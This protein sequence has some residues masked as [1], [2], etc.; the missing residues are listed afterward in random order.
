SLFIVDLGVLNITSQKPAN[1]LDFFDKILPDGIFDYDIY[2]KL[3]NY[4]LN[5]K[6]LSFGGDTKALAV[7]AKLAKHE[8]PVD[9]KNIKTFAK[10]VRLKADENGTASYEFKT[11]NGFNSA[12]R[13]DAVSSNDTQMDAKHSQII[14][15][16]D[17]II[18][19]TVLA[20]M[21][22]GDVLNA[23]LRLINTTNQDKNL[24]ILIKSSPNLEL[25]TDSNVS[26][27]PLENKILPLKIT[28]KDIGKAN[29]NIE[30]NDGNNIMNNETNLDIISPYPISTYARSLTLS[31][32]K[33]IKLPQGFRN[34]S[35][36]ASNSVTSLLSA[37]SENL[38]QYPYGCAE[39]RSSRLLALLNARVKENFKQEDRKRFIT[40]GLQELIKKQKRDGSFGYWDELSYV[41]TFASIYATDL[42]LE[43]DAA[44]YKVHKSVK[45]QALKS[46]EGLKYETSFELLY[47]LYLSAKNNIIDRSALNSIY[48]QKI[49]TSSVLNKYLMASALKI[50]GLDD[51]AQ[52][53]LKNLNATDD[54]E[55]RIYSD[56]H[57][58][59]RDRA[60]VLY[61]HAKHFKPNS[62]SDELANF[63][64]TNMDNLHSTQERAFALR[65]L[66]AYFKPTADETN[67]KFKLIY[68]GQDREFDGLLSVNITTKNGEFR[69]EPQGENKLFAGISSS[70]Y[71]PLEIK[72]AI[73][74]K[75]LDIYRIF[76][77]KNGK[78]VNL[79]SLKV[80]DVIYSK[81]TLNS[82]SPIANGVI[83]EIVSPCFEV[84][85]ENLSGFTRDESAKNNITLEYQTIKDDRV[86]SFY[87]L[88]NKKAALFTPYRVVMSGK[89]MLPAVITENMYNDTQNDYDLAQKSFTIK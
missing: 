47:A 34:V 5:G 31:N 65:A 37:A 16:D 11:P 35:I 4:R 74:P 44:G 53:A 89:C 72:H 73:E 7:E 18:K 32:P 78:E 69:L 52:S 30:L 57:S 1:P 55:K 50:L 83:N 85:N 45:E 8:S 58:D 84:V 24:R 87:N 2:D 13:V 66:N 17:V 81:I 15:K 54:K 82:K 42:V 76:V 39:Q 46:L 10:S 41:N 12:I 77:D 71:V 38:I 86:I 48:D 51:E 67:N 33:D 59:M 68:D 21:L 64:V 49:Y 28:G 27:K 29:F 22:K 3:T 23:S 6:V 61:L 20:Y 79:S 75:E 88:E 43:L 40:L 62:F 70:A 80:N 26:L 36:D 56:F 63:L 14:V 9:N 19:P 60:F 25:N